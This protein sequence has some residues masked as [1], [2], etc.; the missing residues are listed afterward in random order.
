MD[1]FRFDLAA[2]SAASASD[3][4]ATRR[5][6]RRSAGPGAVAGE[7]D[8]RAMG[9]R[10]GRIRA[11]AS[12]RRGGANGTASSAT[13]CATSGAG[14]RDASRLA[15]RISGSRDLFGHGGRRP[16]ASVNIV[17]VH[18][19]FTL[20]DLVSYNAKHNE[21]NGEDNRDGTDDNRSWNCGVEGP[22][23]DPAVLELRERQRR[24]LLATLML[25]EGVPLLLGGDEFART[26]GGNNNAYCQDDELT[27]FDW[28]RPPRT[29]PRR[30]HCRLCRLREQHRVFRRVSS[31][32]A[33]PRT[34]RARRSRL[35]QAGRPADER[36]GLGS[37][38]R[39]GG[40][41]GVERGPATR[42]VP[43]SRS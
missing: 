8:R 41:R 33:R 40:D 38:L 42:R 14:P 11:R 32:P 30:V 23:D 10:V 1:G 34:R 31:S 24:N 22:S 28:A 12:F 3:F 13:P 26:Q 27:W 5:S 39:A 29:R 7:A 16:T 25:S 4:D 17:T 18:D 43:M 36:R 2:A 21:A 35:V 19:G 6:W 9:H 15:T 20:A 37:V